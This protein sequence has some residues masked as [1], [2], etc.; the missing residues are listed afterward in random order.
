MDSDSGF[1]EDRKPRRRKLARSVGP[2]DAAVAGIEIDGSLVMYDDDPLR[3]E[4][5]F[6][7]W[8]NVLPG[9]AKTRMTTLNT[10]TRRLL[11]DRLGEPDWH[12]K[13]TVPWFPLWVPSADWM[14]TLS[15]FV[16]PATVA[17]ILE[18]R[19]EERKPAAKRPEQTIP[20]VFTFEEH[21]LC[22]P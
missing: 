3:W 18:G 5:A 15:W 8:W 19:Y 16:E 21:E 9:V 14:P 12:W 22:E 6:I 17:K 10:A 1:V 13:Q 11:M 20:D 4:A 2:A 7:A